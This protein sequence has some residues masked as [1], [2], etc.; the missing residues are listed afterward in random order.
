MSLLPFSHLRSR[1]VTR[2]VLVQEHEGSGHAAVR[3]GGEEE[4]RVG[5]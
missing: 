1:T 5:T 3:V 4:W 2:L